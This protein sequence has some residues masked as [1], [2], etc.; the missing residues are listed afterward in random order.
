MRDLRFHKQLYS[1]QALEVAVSA[2]KEFAQIERRDESDH[3]VVTFAANDATQESELAGEFS[4]Y[5]LGATVYTAGKE[6]G[7]T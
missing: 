3:L 1:E 4:N 7:A 5:V 6:G 2:F